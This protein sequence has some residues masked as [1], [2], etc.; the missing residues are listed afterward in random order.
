MTEI[1]KVDPNKAE[2]RA[3]ESTMEKA[4]R[5]LEQGREAEKALQDA[6]AKLDAVH[7]EMKTD[8]AIAQLLEADDQNNEAKNKQKVSALHK[9]VRL[10]IGRVGGNRNAELPTSLNGKD[11]VLKLENASDK[12]CEIRVVDAQSEH[13]LHD[14]RID[15]NLS[16][17]MMVQ[18]AGYNYKDS[19]STSIKTGEVSTGEERSSFWR[20]N[21][22]G[23]TNFSAQNLDELEGFSAVENLISSTVAQ[24][25]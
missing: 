4:A 15:T 22:E 2:V 19:E 3:G 24:A 21:S 13:I 5:L 17:E 7:E 11:V 23:S 12:G 25:A 9:N 6:R 18:S 8:P 1:A 10:L 16:G 20:K 14:L